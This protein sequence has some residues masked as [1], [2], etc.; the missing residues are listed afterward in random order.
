MLQVAAVTVDPL[1]DL[2][3]T[4]ALTL[5]QLTGCA[6]AAAVPGL[7]VASHRRLTRR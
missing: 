4:A 1:R 5:P 7:A 2:L 3:G 6:V